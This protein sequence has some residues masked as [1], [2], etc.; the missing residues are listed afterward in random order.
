MW[1]TLRS[2]H[3]LSENLRKATAAMAVFSVFAFADGSAPQ[4]DSAFV[5]AAVPEVTENVAS[6]TSID[7]AVATLDT[8]AIA[9]TAT[10]VVQDSLAETNLQSANLLEADSAPLD[11]LKTDQLKTVLYLSGGERSPWFHLG[12]LYAVEEYGIPVDSVVGTSW[13]AW[14]GSLWTK[15]VALDEIQRLLMDPYIVSYVGHDL[16][17]PQNRIGVEKRDPFEIPLSEEGVPSLR[18]RFTLSSDSS[19]S[20]SRNKKSLRVDSLNLKRSLAKLR[21][22]E[23]L[24]RQTI[25]HDIPFSVQGCEGKDVGNR[26]A[27]VIASLPL[28]ND[29]SAETPVSGELCPHFA[30][31]VEDKVSE[32]PIVVVADPLRSAPMGDP[33]SKLLKRMAG[34]R[35]RNLPGAT[36]R[37]HSALDT[38][39]FAMIQLGF[40]TL[41]RYL[42]DFTPLGNRRVSYANV[43]RNREA[44]KSWFRFDPVFDSLSAET[45]RAVKTYWPESDTG[46]VALEKFAEKLLKN[47]AYDSLGFEMQP[48]GDLMVS[49]AVHPTFDIAAGGFGSN[50]L[51][52]NAYFEG[53]INFVNQMEISLVLSGFYGTS[54]YGIQPRLEVSKLWNKNWGLRFGFDYL[55][56]RPLNSFNNEIPLFL[57]ID[58]EER[59]DLTMSVVYDV[60]EHQSFS[61]NFLFGHR[62]YEM[63]GFKNV[64]VNPVA[65]T[66]NYKYIDGDVKPWFAQNGLMVSASAG[67]E[68]VGFDDGFNDIIPIYWK[69]FGDAQYAV[70]PKSFATFMAGVSGGIERYRGIGGYTSPASFGYAPLDMAYR[71]QVQATPWSTEWYNAELASHEYGLI[72]GSAGLHKGPAG[73]WL[74]AA[75]FHDFEGSPYAELSRNKF[76]L[77]PALRLSYKS[78]ELYTGMNRI[79]DGNSVADLL[80]FRDYTYFIRI[81]NYRF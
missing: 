45:H 42:A 46:F 71:F 78:F 20:I 41:E 7:S 58:S 10:E 75:Y 70:S 30:V 18:Q 60:D 34:E 43:F 24:Y 25:S 29:G 62:E 48:T 37:A 5:A 28:W 22:Q 68:S 12:V 61:A 21:L 65:P 8:A 3:R 49:A 9:V 19:G 4:I 56:L 57:R 13:G 36:I 69:F 27:D 32:F 63:A 23:V 50:V 72:R 38:S 59:S 47:P 17:D 54:S 2:S 14:V 15:G 52:A 76:I 6:T 40:S 53:S 44:K 79:V 74:F 51:G 66:L 67:L 33:R 81:G 35:V 73:L 1:P 55:N 31:P 39:R 26:P 11:S 77:E 80:K 64:K 16:S